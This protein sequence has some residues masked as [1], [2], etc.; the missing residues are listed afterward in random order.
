MKYVIL[1]ALLI[2]ATPATAQWQVHDQNGWAAKPGPEYAAK[3]EFG[4]HQISTTD[5]EMLQKVWAQPSPGVDISTQDEATRNQPI[6]SFVI[7]R[8]CKAAAD[9]NCH[10]STRFVIL[11]PKGKPYG[12]MSKA[13]IWDMPPPPKGNL[14]LGQGASGLR[15]E[16]GEMLGKYR[17]IA[18][19]TDNVA[20][21]TL[22]TQQILTIRE[23]PLAGGWSSVQ[24]PDSDPEIR[25]AA[26][27]VL[28]QISIGNAKLLR[29]EKALRQVVAGTNIRLTLR[30]VDG[31]RW[32]ALVWHKLDGSFEAQAPSRVQ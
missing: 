2:V 19:T 4:T 3:S 18:H 15:V 23:A 32:G 5:P 12:K 1:P 30:L 8:G 25:A 22:T 6:F 26:T 28:G 11:D 24:N 20:K 16:D 13:P 29:V 31:T 14:Q 17:V 7:F 10:V 27:A 9:G 21:I